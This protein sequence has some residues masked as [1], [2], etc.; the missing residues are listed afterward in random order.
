M[1]LIDKLKIANRPLITFSHG[2]GDFLLHLPIYKEVIKQAGKKV[3][4]GVQSKRHFHLIY[5]GLVLTDKIDVKS[6]YDFIQPIKYAEPFGEYSK[7]LQC[8]FSE[9][10]LTD[11][12]WEPYKFQNNVSNKK[13]KRIGVHFFGH[14]GFNKQSKF[15]PIKVA[16]KIWKE[17][18]LAGYE[19]FELYQRTNFTK[20][21]FLNSEI[22][23]KFDL[24]T[25]ENSLRFEQPNLKLVFEEI[26]KCR[27]FIGV[28]SG[29]LYLSLSLLG[30]NSIIGLENKKKISRYLPTKITTVNVDD[31]KDGSV[32]NLLKQMKEEVDI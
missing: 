8:A 25:K 24:A 14:S 28:D 12:Q 13:S 30:E 17:I 3:D 5:S 7:P 29:L 9:Y 27:F 23:D 21:Y 1:R 16:E 2:L 15:C 19:P 26:K 20:D 22:P 4:L 11:F 10:G 32:F 6:R 31:Y 18:E